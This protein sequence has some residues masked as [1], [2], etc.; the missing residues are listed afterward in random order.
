M[1]TQ[2]VVLEESPTLDLSSNQSDLSFGALCI[3]ALIPQHHVTAV[4]GGKPTQK[5]NSGPSTAAAKTKLPPTG[6]SRW[7]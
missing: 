7:H 2:L 6:T 3:D 1:A 4:L 5:S